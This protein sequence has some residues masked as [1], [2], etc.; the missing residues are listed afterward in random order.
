MLEKRGEFNNSMSQF[1]LLFEKRRNSFVRITNSPLNWQ[2]TALKNS[3]IVH[4]CC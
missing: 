1:I 4:S 2:H 3:E